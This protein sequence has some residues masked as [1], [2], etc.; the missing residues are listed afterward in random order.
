APGTPPRRRESVRLPRGRDQRGSAEGELPTVMSIVTGSPLRKTMPAGGW[1]SNEWPLSSRT[2]ASLRST[3]T[4]RPV[5]RG[6]PGTVVPGATAT[7]AG[8]AVDGGPG[9]TTTV[10]AAGATTAGGG[11]VSTP[12]GATAP[13][14]GFD[15][16][17]TYCPF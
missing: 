7:T 13:E 9:V 15:C 6:A 3:S 12:P 5:I 14:V 2:L 16:T 17:T 4:T 8:A 11:E 1:N 10:G